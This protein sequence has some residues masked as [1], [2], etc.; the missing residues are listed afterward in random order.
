MKKTFLKG[1][2]HICFLSCSIHPRYKEEVSFRLSLGARAVAY[3]D[4]QV[5]HQGPFPSAV[6]VE[7]TYLMVTYDQNISATFSK[8]MFEVTF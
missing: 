1:Q 4:K 6:D 7:D 8:D 2:Q 3:G 5:A